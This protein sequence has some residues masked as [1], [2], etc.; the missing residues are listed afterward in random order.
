M[1]DTIGARDV[2]IGARTADP[3]TAEVVRSAMETVCFEMATY[4]SRTATTPIL[5]QSNERNATILTAGG[6]LAALSVGVP[7]FMLTSTLPVQFAL[8]FFGDELYPGDVIVAND[9]YHGGGHLPDFNVFAPVFDGDRLVLI[10]SIQCHHGDTGGAMAGGY[11]VNAADIWSEGVRYPSL[12]IFE[13]GRERRDVVHLMRTN[14]RLPGFVGD[15]RSQVGAAQLGVRRLEEI[16]ERYG[17]DTVLGS[18]EAN[19]A[20]T[21]RRFHEEIASWPDGTYEADAYVDNDPVGNEDLLVHVAVTVEGDHL[22]VDFTGSDARQEIQG[23]STYGNTR[24]YVIAQLAS[25][26]DSS[27]PK[28]EGFFECIT[29]VIPEGTCVNPVVGKPVSSGTHH[30]GVEVGDAIALALSQII[31]DRC[32]PQTYKI[33][34]P[35][36]MWGDRNPRAHDRPFFDDGGE[37]YAGWCRRGARRRRL[38]RA[39]R[40][41]RQPHQGHRGDQRDDLPVDD[42]RAGVHHRLRRGG[43]VAGPSREPLRQGS[44]RPDL[45]EPVHGEPPSH[46]SR[47]PRRPHRDR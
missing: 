19:I 21:A 2:G 20:D 37:L 44:A 24:G 17:A 35:R 1:V 26:V 47:D 7:Q 36:Q 22:T 33:G 45:C 12:K 46:P 14:N 3:I 43:A 11:N 23:W 29:L 40:V 42:P 28:N 9:P 34:A 8:E 5:N 41:V 27:I 32:T 4:V 38:G 25:L 6:E 31:P 15:L 30:P 13:A 39:E 10:A 18:V 16:I